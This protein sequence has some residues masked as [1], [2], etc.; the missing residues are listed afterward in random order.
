M[1]KIAFIGAG[2]L[3]F[4]RNLVRDVLTFPLLQDATLSLMDIDPERLEFARDQSS[5][6]SIWGN[7]LPQSPPPLI[8]QKPCVTPISF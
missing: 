3:G 5:A 7:T 8:A 1:V 2:S 4:T 6:S